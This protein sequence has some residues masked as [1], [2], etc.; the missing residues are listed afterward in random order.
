[1]DIDPQRLP[2]GP[3]LLRQRVTSLVQE[4]EARER[5]RR[6]RQHW[7]E[8]LL[9]ARYGPRCEGVNED[10][11]FL[12]AGALVSAGREAPAEPAA[13]ASSEKAPAGTGK[14][15][16]HGRGALPKSF[17]RQR[18][19]YDL[20]EGQ[21]QCPQ[22]QGDLKGIG[23]EVSERL[24]YVPAS[25]VLIQEACQKYAC[26]KG[27]TVVTAAKPTPP[28]EKGLAGP[29]L[30]AQGAVSKYADPLPLHRQEE[31]FRRQGGELPRQTMCDWRRACAE[32]VSPLYER[33]K[34]RGLGS[35]A[36]QT[37]D[38]PVP[39]RDPDLP[40]TRTGRIWT[41]VGDEAHPFTSAEPTGRTAPRPMASRPLRSGRKGRGISSMARSRRASG[42]T[43]VYDPAGAFRRSKKPL[44]ADLPHE[45]GRRA[46][47]LID[48]TL[49]PRY[50][51]PP[52]K[53]TELNFLVDL[54]ARWRGP[55]F[56]F[57][58]R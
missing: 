24:E 25:L 26:A 10:Q 50:L 6:Q 4:V 34:Q 21:R 2:E 33:M 9:R 44:P 35:K 46:Q 16:G 30:L 13:S 51:P 41:Y 14:P 31:I 27:C 45:V 15:K 53:Q 22:C 19:V 47:E 57:C 37:D 39:V 43:W 1:V 55:F 28:I 20:A 3:A 23:E 8:Q 48:S 56:Y 58:S 52:P 18:V 17:Q 5:R 40:R 32:R 38:T 36:V 12:F 7:L 49:K 29:G 11:L 42:W 54:Y